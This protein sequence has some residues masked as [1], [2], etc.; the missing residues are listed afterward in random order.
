MY[1]VRFTIN[2]G[3][4]SAI[5][6]NTP[7]QRIQSVL[8]AKNDTRKEDGKRFYDVTCQHDTMISLPAMKL[9]KN[10]K[11]HPEQ[12]SRC[13]VLFRS[14]DWFYYDMLDDSPELDD[15]CKSCARNHSF[16]SYEPI[17]LSKREFEDK[18]C[19][20]RETEEITDSNDSVSDENEAV[21]QL[22]MDPPDRKVIRQLAE[23]AKI[24]VAESIRSSDGQNCGPEVSSFVEARVALAIYECAHNLKQKES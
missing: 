21:Q 3:C 4:P 16:M 15:L 12:C 5:S 17:P 18:W 1:L 11:P 14:G 19:L 13:G 7:Q 23:A 8:V 9:P 24:A 6:S 2:H 22:S 10:E 20:S